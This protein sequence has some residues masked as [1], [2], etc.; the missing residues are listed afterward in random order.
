M[1]ELEE[2]VDWLIVGDSSANQGVMPSEIQRM[3]G[4]KALNLGTIGNMT[5]VEDLWMLEEYIDRFGPPEKVVVVH[6]FDMWNRYFDPLL[7]S[8]IPLPWG[9]WEKYTFAHELIGDQ[10]RETIFIDRF[11]PLYTQDWTLRS[12]IYSSVTGLKNPFNPGLFVYPDGFFPSEE[13]KPEQAEQ[14]ALDQVEFVEDNAFFVSDINRSAMEEI[15]RLA[16]E[17]SFD[18]YLVNSPIHERLYGSPIFQEYA[19]GMHAEL[20]GFDRQ[21]ERVHYLEAYKTFASHLM[22]TS[23][24]LITPA[25][26]TYTQWLVDSLMNAEKSDN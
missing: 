11:I 17:Y 8:Q 20:A 10:E 16:E 15:I 21:S 1:T 19:G 13:A 2:P 25:A 22:Q 12:I 6:V 5:V 14:D 7:T 24:H 23:D 26:E 18:V 3:T 4:K 9:F